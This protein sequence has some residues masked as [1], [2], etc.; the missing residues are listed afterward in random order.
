MTQDQK[1]VITAED[2]SSSGQIP[3]SSQINTDPTPIAP[4]V[5]LWWRILSLLLIL[6]PPILFFFVMG[7][8]LRTRRDDITKRY[9]YALQGC[10]ALLTCVLLWTIILSV[11]AVFVQHTQNVGETEVSALSMQTFPALPSNIAL[12]GR[13]ISQMMLSL[14]TVVHQSKSGLLPTRRQPIGS[15]SVVYAGPKGYLIATSRHV[16]E[17][18][19]RPTQLGSSV[20]VTLQDGQ[21]AAAVIAGLHKELDI[22]LLWVARVEG[23]N[24][25]F[26]QPIREFQ[27]IEIGEQIYVIGHPEGLEFSLSGGMV[28][29]IRGDELLQISAPV[30]PGSSGG[31]V[32]DLHGNLIAIIQGV[33]DKSKSPNAENLNFAVRIDDLANIDA[34]TINDEGIEGITALSNRTLFEEE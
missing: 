12:G 9:T 21:S 25:T 6:C 3:T 13:E 19:S 11:L 8:L 32:Y 17:A 7:R 31:P 5:P 20:G 33:V 14:A 22:A 26:V 15:G 10:W 29:Q 16:A 2:L 24:N 28:T 1:I 27:T 34:W 4:C 23:Q 18:L 30:S